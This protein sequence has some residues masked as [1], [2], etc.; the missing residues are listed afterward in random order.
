[1]NFA[2]GKSE[3]LVVLSGRGAVAASALLG[4]LPMSDGGDLQFPV[5]ILDCGDGI[6]L[7]IVPVYKHLGGM[8]SGSSSMG[9]EVTARCAAA[10]VACAPCNGRVW[11]SRPLKRRPG[12]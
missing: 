9:V 11:G 8:I 12:S 5:P 1:M 2:A 7:R 10:R 6:L 3:A 4:A